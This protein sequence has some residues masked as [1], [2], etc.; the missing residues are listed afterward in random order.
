MDKADVYRG[1]RTVVPHPDPGWKEHF[2]LGGVSLDMLLA[3]LTKRGHGK[4]R[5]KRSISRLA[6]R[7]LS[8]VAMA[9]YKHD[10]YII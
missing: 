9:Y 7:Y 4:S 5:N 10:I 2:C 1:I 8:V 3:Q 6:W